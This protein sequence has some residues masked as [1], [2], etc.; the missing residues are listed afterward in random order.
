MSKNIHIRGYQEADRVQVQEI[1]I[2]TGGTIFE[3]K[4]MQDLLLTAF[5]NYYI[6]Q[7]P[8]NCFV[9]VDGDHVVG[10]ILCARDCGVWAETFE[11]NYVT[12]APVDGLKMFYKGTMDMP[13]KHAGEYPAHLHIDILPEYQRMG[14][15]FKLMD[16]LISHLKAL[17]VS[18]LMLSVAG[19]NT[20]GKNFY[21]KYGFSVLEQTSVEIAMGILL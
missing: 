14:I 18:G 10:Y 6:E 15:G 20:K 4:E 1:C 7:E 17:G 8:E 11:E 3:Q 13:Q 12:K 9:A 2:A 19:D 5:C 16:A 21:G